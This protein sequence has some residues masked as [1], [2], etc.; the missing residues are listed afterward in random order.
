LLGG[1]L[2]EAVA[3]AGTLTPAV[4]AQAQIELT[5]VLKQI[6]R[7]LAKLPSAFANAR[8]ILRSVT[9]FERLQ[10]AGQRFQVVDMQVIAHSFDTA[11]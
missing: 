3:T 11:T 9:G 10:K 6:A 4:A 8:H 7:V 5:W 2:F 1:Y